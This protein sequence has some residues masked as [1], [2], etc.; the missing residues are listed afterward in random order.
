M[1]LWGESSGVYDYEGVP[2]S[3]V[4]WG[5]A[6]SDNNYFSGR[7][8]FLP[9]GSLLRDPLSGGILNANA[10]YWIYKAGGSDVPAWADPVNW[11]ASSAGLLKYYTQIFARGGPSWHLGLET[12]S[13][14]NIIHIGR[15][16]KFGVHLAVGAER[17][18]VAYHHL[19]L[20]NRFP[21]LRYWRPGR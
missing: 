13:N 6:D 2:I 1:S 19:Y 20:M 5:Y 15:H 8:E 9:D 17:P 18:F 12:R 11:V 10:E 14:M 3:Y 4:N 21:F 7:Y 16:P